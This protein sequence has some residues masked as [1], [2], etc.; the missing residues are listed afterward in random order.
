MQPATNPSALRVQ[1]AL[2][3]GFTVLE[4]PAG[5]RPA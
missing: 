1:S 3:D 2:G 4:F 5:T